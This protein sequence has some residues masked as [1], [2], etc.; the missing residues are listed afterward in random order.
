MIRPFFKK[1]YLSI[2]FGLLLIAGLYFISLYSYV[3]YHS[4]VELFSIII[5]FGVFIIAWNS[6]K[7]LDNNY[8]LFVGISYFFVA[9]LDLFHTLAYR[10]MGIFIN[11]EGSNLATQLW[12][13][14]RYLESIS[15]LLAIFFITRKLNYKLQFTCY[16]IVTT[17]ILLSIFYWE[18]FP[19]S[20]VEGS[21]LTTFKITSEYIISFILAVAIFFLHLYR[22]EF[23]RTVFH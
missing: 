8:L 4:F 18:I 14:A 19:V 12:I 16:L 3:L 22:K 9:L 1:N 7:F 5:A 20:Y 11:F 2:I 13:S 10:G 6:K 17:L 21:G 23:N 15:L